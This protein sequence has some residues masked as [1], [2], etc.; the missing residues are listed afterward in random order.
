MIEPKNQESKT[1]L[2][3]LLRAIGE[4]RE[5][6]TQESLTLLRARLRIIGEMRGPKMQESHSLLRA[7]GDQRVLGEGRGLMIQSLLKAIEELMKGEVLSIPAESLGIGIGTRKRIRL[8]KL[9]L[10]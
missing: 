4:M 9:T 3:A 10:G 8:Q 7:L 6:K 2:G 5:P 1:L